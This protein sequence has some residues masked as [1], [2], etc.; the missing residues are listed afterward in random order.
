MEDLCIYVRFTSYGNLDLKTYLR[1]M[2]KVPPGLDSP[3]PPLPL[4]RDSQ[5]LTDQ[6]RVRGKDQ[7]DPAL[8]QDGQSSVRP[9]CSSQHQGQVLQADLSSTV[10]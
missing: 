9:G 5:E 1:E 10:C 7:L 2:L 4:L 8:L 6:F 3:H